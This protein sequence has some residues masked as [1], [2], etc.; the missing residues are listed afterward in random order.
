MDGLQT[1]VVTPCYGGSDPPGAANS[2]WIYLEAIADAIRFESVPPGATN[3]ASD[4]ELLQVVGAL[5]VIDCVDALITAVLNADEASFPRCVLHLEAVTDESPTL[6]GMASRRLRRLIGSSWFESLQRTRHVLCDR[7]RQVAETMTRATEEKGDAP[8]D[9]R[10]PPS[11]GAFGRIHL[12]SLY[13]RGDAPP[14]L[15]SRP[16]SE[17]SRRQEPTLS[18]REL[19]VVRFVS[20]GLTNKEIAI[21]LELSPNTI[22]RHMA[23]VLRRLGV[24]KRSAV[25][26]WYATHLRADI[27]AWQEAR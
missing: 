8:T 23:R 9:T 25:A 6:M 1:N 11:A 14:R 10:Q 5:R 17:R 15:F 16:A 3:A 7:L 22:K 12:D 4:E 27:Q 20:E 18:P 19:D 24:A 2:R 21:R 26:T 13:G